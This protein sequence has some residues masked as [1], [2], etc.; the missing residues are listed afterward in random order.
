MQDQI[1]MLHA[2]LVCETKRNRALQ[3]EHD[4]LAEHHGILTEQQLGG[5][6]GKNS[7][8]FRTTR[9]M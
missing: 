8:L 4:E 9:R 6:F 2:R 1:D 7:D 3:A 5:S